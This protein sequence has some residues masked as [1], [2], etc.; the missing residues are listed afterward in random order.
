MFSPKKMKSVLVKSTFI[1]PHKHRHSVCKVT[2]WYSPHIVPGGLKDLPV[3]LFISELLPFFHAF[4]KAPEVPSL[5]HPFP[6][7]PCSCHSQ[8]YLSVP[9]SWLFTFSS[10]PLCLWDLL[11]HPE[12]TVGRFPQAVHC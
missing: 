3:L 6:Q 2:L 12:L 11:F 8:L 7:L 5:L 9:F 10:S 4:T 1:H